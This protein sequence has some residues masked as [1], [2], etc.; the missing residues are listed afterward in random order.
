MIADEFSAHHAVYYNVACLYYGAVEFVLMPVL[1][2]LSVE[3]NVERGLK[4][5]RF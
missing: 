1:K 3:L 4:V 5:C 2:V